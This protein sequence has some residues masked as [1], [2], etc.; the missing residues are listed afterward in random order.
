MGV[1]ACDGGGGRGAGGGKQSPAKLGLT[2][3]EGVWG[4]IS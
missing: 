2:W 4:N 1:L 3:R